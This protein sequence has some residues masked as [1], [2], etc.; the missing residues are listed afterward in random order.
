M[1]ARI[2]RAQSYRNLWLVKAAAG[3]PIAE[4]SL[5]RLL[6]DT[7]SSYTVLPVKVLETMGCAVSRSKTIPIVA[8][9]GILQAPIVT[10]PWFSC[11]GQRVENF[12]VV[13]LDLPT[14][15]FTSGLLGMDFLQR[16]GIIIN[17]GKGELI[18]P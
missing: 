5:F 13:A 14:N 9:G 12:Q 1:T 7:G 15:A 17:T 8:A 16:F 2:Y 6:I 4:P 18:I 11:L 10:I 3:S